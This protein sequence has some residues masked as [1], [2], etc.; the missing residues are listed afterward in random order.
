MYYVEY[1]LPNREVVKA[2]IASYVLKE[3]GDV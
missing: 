2:C 3:L 1:T